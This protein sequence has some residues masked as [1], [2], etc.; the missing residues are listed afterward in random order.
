M[1]L[2]ESG[3]WHWQRGLG[4]NRAGE[5]GQGGATGVPAEAAPD[6]TE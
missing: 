3:G 4:R 6:P 1:I 2:A 5:H